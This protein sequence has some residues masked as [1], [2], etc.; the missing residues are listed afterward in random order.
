VI[1]TEDWKRAL[2]E[3]WAIRGDGKKRSR[4]VAYG[5]KKKPAMPAFR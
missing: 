5:K 4:V 1:G 2:V 3:L